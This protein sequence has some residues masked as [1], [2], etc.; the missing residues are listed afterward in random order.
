MYIVPRAAPDKPGMPL[1]GYFVVVGTALTAL[2]FAADAYMPR[3]AGLS[4]AS[5]FDGLP[6][7]YKGEPASRRP[8]PAPHIASIAPVA[9]TTGSA[10]A[11]EPK[12][13]ASSP[14]AQQQPVQEAAKPAKPQRKIVHR[15]PRQDEN[16]W[17]GGNNG[18]R[19][20]A[21]GSRDPFSSSRE[22]EPSWRDSWAAGGFD[23][24]R[25]TRSRRSASR[26]NT[27][28]WSFR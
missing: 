23:Q 26:P 19:D 21:S 22:R 8:A 16:D 25:E 12:A 24:P 7:D 5:N 15:K 27:D 4:F 2:L 18:R 6:A 11:S 14:V 20:F 1:L 17:F 13:Q 9:E 3:P 28:F 10:P